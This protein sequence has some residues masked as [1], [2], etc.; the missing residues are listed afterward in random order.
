MITPRTVLITG[1]TGGMGRAC[2]LLAASCGDNLLLSDIDAQKLAA[3]AQECELLG[4]QVSCRTLNICDSAGVSRLVA[5]LAGD[6]KISACIHTVGLSPEMAKWDRIVEVDLIATVRFIE[7]IRPALQ[8][9]GC[10][11]VIASMSAHLVPPNAAID[12]LL[13]SPLQPDVL[14]LASELEGAPLADAGLAYAYAK[15]ALIQY[16]KREA[17]AWGEEGKRLVSLSP[18]MIDTEMGRLE[19]D[20]KT[21]QYAAMRKLVALQRDGNPREIAG[22]AL[23]LVSDAASYITGTDLLVDGGFVGALSNL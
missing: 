17:R 9:G 2:A 23:F 1:A 18:G 10:A 15:R 21:D 6:R 5:E 11:L 14:A 3:L 20:S 7:A 12:T 22:A 4:V 19:A 13:F 8:I 16:V